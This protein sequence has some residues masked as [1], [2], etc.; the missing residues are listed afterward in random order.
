MTRVPSLRELRAHTPSNV[1]ILPTAAAR[2]VQ[3]P[4]NKQTRDQKRSLQDANPWP[5][6]YFRPG[7]REAI[8][9][10]KLVRSVRQTPALRIVFAVLE[11]MDLETRQKVVAR[12]AIDAR[13]GSVES[14]QALAISECACLS[15]GEQLDMCFAFEWLAERDE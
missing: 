9:K 2:Q 12:L 8:Q 11:A 6:E 10:A 3:Q 14:L 5:G 7:E 1:V 15:G 4:W 13:H